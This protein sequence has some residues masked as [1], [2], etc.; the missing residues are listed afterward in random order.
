M[1]RSYLFVPATSAKMFDKAL[2]S[3]ADCVIFDLEDAVAIS[4]KRAARERARTYLQNTELQKDVFIR[5]N[6]VTTNWWREDL[7]A[8][9]QGGASGVVVPKAESAVSMKI[10]CEAAVSFLERN[11]RVLD[12]FAV[13]PLIETARGV[14][15]AY[16]IAAAHY[17]IKRLVFG[18]ID[19]SLDI[20]CELTSDGTELVYA[21]SNIV[22][23]SRAAGIGSPV[24]AVYPDLANEAGLL[25]EAQRARKLGFKAKL[26]IH[27]KQLEPIHTVFTLSK[28]EVEA[29]LEIVNAFENAEQ[30]G[31]ASISVGNK[32]V[33]YPVYKKAKGLVEFAS[34]QEI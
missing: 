27:P 29:A 14:Q 10:L 34:L 6:D 4:E 1:I 12:S 8:A 3:I 11:N 7:E 21:R 13:L 28:Q 15:F 26:A 32:L 18:S 17:F 22:N 20:D 19:Y 5:I 23:A 31:I 16:E 30:Q 33:D 24:D 2:A 25:D 9:I